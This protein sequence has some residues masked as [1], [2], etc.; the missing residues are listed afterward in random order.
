MALRSGLA[1]QVGLAEELSNE[2]VTITATGTVSGGTYTITVNGQT[3]A[4]IDYNDVNADVI[5]ALEALSNIAPGEVVASGGALPT[6]PLVLTFGGTLQDTDLTISV[7]SASLTGG[8]SYTATETTKGGQSAYGVYETPDRFLEFV[9]ESLAHTIEPIEGTALRT[10]NRVLRAD[11][12]AQG[13]VAVEGDIEYEVLSKGF[14]LWFKHMLGTVNTSTPGGATL[15]RDHEFTLGDLYGKSLTVQ[16]GRPGVDGTVYPFSYSGIKVASWEIS[17]EVDGVVML[18][19]SLDGQREDLDQSLAVASFP[20]DDSLFYWI[21]GEITIGGSTFCVTSATVSGDN[22][23]AVERYFICGG[24]GQYK[25][26]PVHNA[27]AELTGSLEAE[28]TNPTA[29]ERFVNGETVAVTLNWEGPEIE[30][31]FNYG[32]TIELPEVRFDGE[33]PSVGG[34]DV[35]TQTLSFKVLND[36]SSEPITLTYRTTD[37]SV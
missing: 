10:G 16:V 3:T 23:L 1:G 19:V 29:Y 2:V 17:N 8:G 18:T 34:P 5:S 14:G 4:A 15:T 33:T 7:S 11:R 21:G 27:L 24:N 36:G 20:A 22:G 13:R 12:W 28:F 6:T 25:K 30:N 35:L 32:L 9:S 31:G 37:L 26:E